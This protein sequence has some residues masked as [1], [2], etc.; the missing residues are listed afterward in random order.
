M[1]ETVMTFRVDKDLKNAF[2]L[3]GKKIDLTSSQ[4]IR[5]FMRDTV[6]QYMKEN[7]QGSL[8]E[9][10]KKQGNTKTKDKQKSVIPQ[11]WRK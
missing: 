8:L 6:N 3:V 10:T 4:M 7:A 11:S 5:Q 1:N 2:D 9:P